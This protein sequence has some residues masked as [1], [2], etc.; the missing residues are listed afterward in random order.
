MNPVPPV[1]SGTGGRLR[2]S[3]GDSIQ[4]GIQKQDANC[5]EVVVRPAYDP[6]ASPTSILAGTM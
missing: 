2:H 4:G 3:G 1:R 6:F 5:R